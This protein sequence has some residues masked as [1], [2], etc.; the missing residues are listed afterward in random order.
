MDESQTSSNERTP[1]EVAWDEEFESDAQSDLMTDLKGL[2]KFASRI[3][4]ALVQMPA[5]L[6]PEETARHARA[7]ARESFLALRSFLGA[8]G[9]SIEEVLAEPATTTNATATVQGPPGT[10]GT[11]RAAGNTPAT[12][13]SSKVKRIEVSEEE[14]NE[15]RE[16]S[17]EP[18][19]MP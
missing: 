8:I 6:V 5:A 9:D 17:T 1:E 13:S 18:G 15:G 11:G 19:D 14:E 7:A 10:W 16:P 4:G 3:P 12:L 2:A